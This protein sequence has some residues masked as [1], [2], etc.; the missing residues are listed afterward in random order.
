LL[1]VFGNSL[2]QYLVTIQKYWIYGI[3][4]VLYTLG[5]I[6]GTIFFTPYVGAFGP[7]YGTI[8]GSILYVLLRLYGLY[9][10]GGYLSF[11]FWHPDIAHMGQLM[12]PRVVAFFSKL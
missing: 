5:T 3:T 2:G 11:T 6:F 12:L 8:L 7:M 4:P 1:F 9:R 10:S